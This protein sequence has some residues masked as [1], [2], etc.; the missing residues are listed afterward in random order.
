[1]VHEVAGTTVDPVDS[2]VELDGEMWRF[3]DTAGLRK[4]VKTA[5]GME[6][7]ASLR[8]QAAIEAA[9]VAHR[10][11]STPAS[12]SPSRTSG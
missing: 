3:V 12:R 11:A 5:S 9:E 7:Y 10:A 1:M 4:R 6:Y 8:T 2:L